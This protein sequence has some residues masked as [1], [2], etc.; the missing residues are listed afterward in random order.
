MLKIKSLFWANGLFLILFGLFL[1]LK[2]ELALNIVIIIFG[3]EVL[4]SGIIGLIFA[5]QQK[6]YSYRGLLF[7]GS[8]L[9]ILFGILLL[10]IPQIGHFLV[11]LLVVLIGIAILIKGIFMIF[12]GLKAKEFIASRW[13]QVLI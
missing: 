10:A 1:F 6:D 7:F 11:S 5:W 4:L 2:P 8:S 3:I 13:L 9:Q 12:D